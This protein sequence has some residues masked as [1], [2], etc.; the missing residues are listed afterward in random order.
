MKGF[1]PSFVT[2]EGAT[3]EKTAAPDACPTKN[4]PEPETVVAL[5]DES[6]NVAI[7]GVGGTGVLTIGAILGMAAHLEDKAA[8]IQDV[9]G[10][11][12]KGGA[13]LSH[14]RISTSPDMVSSA[15]IP[16]GEADLADGCRY[17]GCLGQGPDQSAI[18]QTAPRPSST[19][20]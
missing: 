16:P 9:S 7:T 11:A 1:C 14:V 2:V 4:L 18:R 19:R 17:G 12:Q 20:I 3:L 8:L 6:Y 13:V 10:L 15:Q 5:G